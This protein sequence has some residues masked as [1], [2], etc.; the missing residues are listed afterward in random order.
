MKSARHQ[1]KLLG[2]GSER[3]SPVDMIRIEIA[4]LFFAFSCVAFA[5]QKPEA[6]LAA[7][8]KA[9]ENQA[10]RVEA[11]V[12]AEKKDLKI[13]GIVFGNDFDL[14]I[15]TTTGV[16]RQ[17]VVGDKAWDSDDGG[18]TWKDGDANDRR[19]YYLAHTP[20]HFGPKEKIPPFE[21]VGTEKEGN[22]SLLHIRF[23]APDKIRYEG[24]RPNWWILLREGKPTT[25]RHYHGPAGLEGDYVRAKVDYS[26]VSDPTPVVPPPGNPRAQAAPAGPEALLMAAMSKMTAGVWEVNGTATYKKTVRIHG[27]LSGTDFDLTME[28]EDG[29]PVS[30]LIVIKDKAWAS[31][32]GG[33]SFHK[34]SPDDRLVYSLAH[35]PIFA[36]RLEPPFEKVGDEQHDGETW[37]HIQLKVAEKVEPKELPQYWLL[38]NGQGQPLYIRRAE[39]PIVN[40]TTN[41][42]TY[43]AFDYLPGKEKTITPPQNA[44][45]KSD[46]PG[47]PVDDK[48]RGFNDIEQ[49]KF[50]LAGKV[51]RIE[52]TP[53][54]LQ[55]QQIAEG[56][57]RAMLKDT[58]M[59]KASYGQVEFPGEALVKLGFLKKML[60]GI[61]GWTEYQEAGLLG[62]TEGEPVS[63]Y[64]QVIPIGERPAARCVAVGRKVARESNGKA[65]YSW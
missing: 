33:K 47:P 62:R 20:I 43:C 57:Y 32:D 59:P 36:G 23:K 52:V 55:A 11:H 46:A 64:V 1:Q 41:N 56:V 50:D 28:P 65:S 60:P 37:L 63:F 16:T 14:T 30:R 45:T 12:V 40:P 24:D 26:P 54:L 8:K 29:S 19:F 27:L 15:E 35:T 25:I 4:V 51:V 38:L 10:W 49:H 58:V 22:E 13:S 3:T 48:V 44:E 34:G 5:E 61:H 39:I 31:A 17:I 2:A 9:S 42:V 6:I 21:V 18:K 7:A 53:K